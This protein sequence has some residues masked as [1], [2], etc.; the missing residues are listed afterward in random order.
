[1]WKVSKTVVPH[2]P[3]GWRSYTG[4]HSVFVGACV[5]VYVY[6]F[7]CWGVVKKVTRKT[8]SKHMS[9]IREQVH[10]GSASCY[11]IR[12]QSGGEVH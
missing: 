8:E 12:E 7:L 6:M 4:V 10:A 2:D 9:F 11:V 1:M 5:S 3:R